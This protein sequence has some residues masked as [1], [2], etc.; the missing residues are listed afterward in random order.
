M[1]SV[2]ISK[3]WLTL[4]VAVSFLCRPALGGPVPEAPALSASEIVQKAV[5]RS[6]QPIPS[7]KSDYIYTKVSV[8][9]ELDATGKVKERQER[10]YQVS[11]HEGCSSL[12]LIEVNGKPPGEAD[13]KK[14]TENETNIR[15][16]LAGSKTARADRRENLLTHELVNRYD[17]KL[18]GQAMVNG[19]ATYKLRFQVKN[20]E[21]AVHHVIDRLLNRLSGTLWIDA[22]EFEVARADIYLGSEV[23]LLGGIIG[24]LKKLAFTVNRTRLPE[25]IWFNSSSS[26][27]FEGRKLLDSTRI[28]TRSQSINF[29]PLG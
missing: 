23:N 3:R 25:G 10:V 24:S 21:P 11:F 13:R 2:L 5:A 27:D 8:T 15:Q 19:R 20:P 4:F 14:Q 28:K 9:E 1:K 26:G 22:E 7:G 16:L 17:F 29:R 12:K 6:G 18:I